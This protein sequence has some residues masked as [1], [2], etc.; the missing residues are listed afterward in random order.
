MI[1]IVGLAVAAGAAFFLGSG[2]GDVT[3]EDATTETDE[4]GEISAVAIVNG[5]EITRTELDTQLVQLRQ[6]PQFQNVQGDAEAEA[7]LERLALDG[8][9]DTRLLLA[10]ARSQGIAAEESTINE[11]IQ[12]L[13]QQFGGQ[14][15][16]EQQLSQVG[17]DEVAFRGQIKDQ[18]V[19][20]QYSS[21]IAEENNVSV[22]D[23]DVR[24]VYDQQFSAQEGAPSFDE[25]ASR[26]RSQLEQQE[27]Q[28]VL[29]SILEELRAEA[30]IEILL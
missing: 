9:I 6:N 14:E 15:A 29:S 17:I 25:V 5:D 24:N 7:Q 13:V 18:L 19:F 27:L 3:M 21:Q 26:I 11:T 1:I 22:K 30:N 4:Q 2:I 12:Q 8:L 20:E 16:F 10:E 23:E 28:Q